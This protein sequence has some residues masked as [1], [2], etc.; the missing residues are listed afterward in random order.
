MN[1]KVSAGLLLALFLGA[2]L[3]VAMPK[4]VS[5]AKDVSSKPTV[6]RKQEQKTRPSAKSERPSAKASHSSNGTVIYDKNGD[7]VQT[8]IVSH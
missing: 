2:G 3:F 1:K 8:T 4:G 6:E 5:D 7:E